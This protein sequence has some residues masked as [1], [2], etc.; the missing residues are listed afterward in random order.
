[1]EE[2]GALELS[3]FPF[4]EPGLASWSA[5]VADSCPLSS[6]TGAVQGERKGSRREWEGLEWGMWVRPKQIL[7]L[8][9]NRSSPGLS[10]DLDRHQV[11]QDPVSSGSP[12]GRA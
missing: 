11:G 8:N 2:L 7:C 6:G 1:M 9:S 3:S 5:S 12:T 4:L 10:C